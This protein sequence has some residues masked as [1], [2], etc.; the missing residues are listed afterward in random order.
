MFGVSWQAELFDELALRLTGIGQ[1]ELVGS[2]ADPAVITDGWSDLDVMITLTRTGQVDLLAGFDAWA[3]SDVRSTESQVLR[4]VLRDGRRLDMVVDGGVVA[5]P[6]LASDNDIRFVAAV[7]AAKM[8][9]GDHLIG[10]HLTL[11]LMRSCLVL[12]MRLRDGDAGTTVHRFGSERDA[13]VTMS[14]HCSVA[15]SRFCLVPTSWSARSSCTVAGGASWTRVTS[16]TGLASARCWTAGSH[17]R[18]DSSAWLMWVV[19]P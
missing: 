5:V 17:D 16:R 8:G 13:L 19:G 12:A 14:R 3:V 10:L 4:I 11:E 2:A 9:R 6:P 7:A 18:P 1:V 15:E